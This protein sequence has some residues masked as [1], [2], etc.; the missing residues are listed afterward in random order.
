MHY[1]S[2]LFALVPAILAAQAPAPTTQSLVAKYAAMIRNY[3]AMAKD[4]AAHKTRIP[5]EA[6][7]E[8]LSVAIAHTADPGVRQLL[9]QARY[10]LF[11]AMRPD[12]E[13]LPP[14]AG[15]YVSSVGTSSMLELCG[16]ITP[17]SPALDL[18]AEISPDFLG[19]IAW[20]KSGGGF[21][22][23]TENSAAAQAFEFYDQVFARHPSRKVKLLALESS[24]DLHS[25]PRQIAEVRQDLARLEAFE[26]TA[27]SIPKWKDWLVKAV[28]EDKVA[29]RA[30]NTIPAFT[31]EELDK[32]GT[33]LTPASFKGKY[34]LLDFWATWCGPCKGELPFVHRAY[35][36]FHPAGLEI[37]SISSDLKAENIAAFRKDP[38]HP[39][40][41]HHAFPQGKAREDLMNLFQV[42][43]IPHVLL[44]G[45][46][47]KIIT[48]DNLRGEDLE[49]TL[50]KYL[51]AK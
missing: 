8:T 50:A 2:A 28:E 10:F 17:D 23:Q 7:P 6:M 42:R 35:A 15:S 27:P 48:L 1:N 21:V 39:M 47:G 5:Q 24:I 37:L 13:K 43:G 12:A 25:R 38:E 26:P 22:N 34:W 40:P 41:W 20:H 51:K 19:F 49:K 3:P 46:D 45:P 33:R 36:R 14:E 29:P 32:P 44:I 11:E 9:L 31:V 30:G 16:Q 18:V 4:E